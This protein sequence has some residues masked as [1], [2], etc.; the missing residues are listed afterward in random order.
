MTRHQKYFF[1]QNPVY[2]K[3]IPDVDVSRQPYHDR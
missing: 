3:G 1:I 2:N